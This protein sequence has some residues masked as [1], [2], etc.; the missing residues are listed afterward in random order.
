MIVL[1]RYHWLRLLFVWHGSVLP[2]VMSRLWLV[3]GLSVVAG[4]IHHWWISH[5]A[6]STLNI[7]IFT[8]LGVSLAI[9]PRLS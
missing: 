2:R 1:P 4:L 6:Q 3:F 9:F 5:H 7:S 8:L